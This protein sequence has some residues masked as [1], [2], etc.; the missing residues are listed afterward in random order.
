M[1]ITTCPRCDGRGRLTAHSVPCVGCNGTG[2]VAK[3]QP[4]RQPDYARLGIDD[5]EGRN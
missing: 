3:P 5:P 4:V 1:N 2:T